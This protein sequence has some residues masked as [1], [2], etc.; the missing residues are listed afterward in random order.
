MKKII[1]LLAVIISFSSCR[2]WLEI[3][4]EGEVLEEEA[5]KNQQ[6]LQNLLTHLTMLWP[7]IIMVAFN[8]LM[9]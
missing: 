9:S 5:V 3:T 7:I 2:K 8:F 6:D 4:P 1:L